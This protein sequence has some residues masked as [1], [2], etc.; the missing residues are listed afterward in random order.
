MSPRAAVIDFINKNLE[1]QSLSEPVRLTDFAQRMPAKC[2]TL[3][4]SI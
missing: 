4:R 3:T 1:S 2:L